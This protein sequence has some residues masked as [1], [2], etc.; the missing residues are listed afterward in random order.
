MYKHSHHHDEWYGRGI[1][2]RKIAFGMIRL[3]WKIYYGIYCCSMWL[4]VTYLE[5]S[6]TVAGSSSNMKMRRSGKPFQRNANANHTIVRFKPHELRCLGKSEVHS[7]QFA[8]WAVLIIIWGT[9][10]ASI[11]SIAHTANANQMSRIIYSLLANSLLC[12]TK[13]WKLTKMRWSHK[14]IHGIKFMVFITDEIY[15]CSFNVLTR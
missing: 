8:R 13:K 7:S 10:N 9:S 11:R 14:L 12:G 5:R 3:F 15:N 6:K 1:K 4:N 2:R